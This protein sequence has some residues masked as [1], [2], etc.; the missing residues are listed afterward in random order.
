MCQRARFQVS[1]DLLDD[2]VVP[3]HPVSGDRVEFVSCNGGEEGVESPRIKQCR[4]L[5][6]RV[7]PEF[8]DTPHDQPPADLLTLFLR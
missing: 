1:V 6:G 4:L 8:G 7:G 5:P 3:M 2:R